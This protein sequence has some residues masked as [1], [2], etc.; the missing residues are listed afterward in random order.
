MPL[1]PVPGR[2]YLYELRTLRHTPVPCGNVWPAMLG[3]SHSIV[4]EITPPETPPGKKLTQLVQPFN[5]DCAL[6]HKAI[7]HRVLTCRTER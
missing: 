3:D 2:F 7:W 6:T 1:H 5:D 4:K